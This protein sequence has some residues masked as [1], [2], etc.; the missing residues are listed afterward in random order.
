[1]SARV[2]SYPGFWGEA[3][4]LRGSVTLR[5]LPSVLAFGWLATLVCLLQWLTAADISIEIGPHE[6]AGGIIGL[7][8]VLRTNAGYE[9][10]WEARKLW[11][12]IVNQS[13]NLA[14]AALAHG[15]TDARWRE[16]VVLWTA[17]FAHAVRAR[18]RGQVSTPELAE[19]VGEAEAA[20][21][22]AQ[23][24]PPTA[25][26]VRLA[27]LLQEARGRGMD[28]FAFLTAERERAGLVDHL[29][30]CERILR[31]PLATVFSITTRRFL[32]L[33]LVSLPF[34]LLKKLS[35]DWLT[36]V[37]TAA[38]A[39]ALLALD[40]IGI[41]LQHPFSTRSL[42]HLPLDDICRNLQHNLLALLAETRVTAG[43][44]PTTEFIALPPDR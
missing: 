28:G 4:A 41:E 24:H 21:L 26:A 31:S 25:V 32:F 13:R 42:S 23:E 9:R 37:M 29:G 3:F 20:K 7:L 10:W 43:D 16:Q 2:D 8:L 15:P 22:A 36:P 14:V 27:A 44:V 39:Y 33:Y 34:A 35:A 5:V 19:L 11:G 12:G 17:A 1:L 30:G 18:L 38:V 40:Q 6:I